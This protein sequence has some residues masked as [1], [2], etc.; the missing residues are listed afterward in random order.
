MEPF[1][2]IFQL[3][4]YD[5]LSSPMK[6]LDCI[7]EVS[8][9]ATLEKLKKLKVLAGKVRG[10]LD[11]GYTNVKGFYCEDNNEL[12]QVT[13]DTQLL[14]FVKDLVDGD[15][16]H[17]YVVHEVDE[18]KEL[19]APTGL[20]PWSDPVDESVGINTEGTVENDSDLN[21]VDTELPGGDTNQNEAE[22]DLPSS[23][24]DVDVIPDEDDSDVDEELR[25]LRAE[26]RNKRNPNLRQKR[27]REKKTITKEVPIGEAG[28]DRGFEDIGINKKDKYVGRLGGDEK[29]I[30]SS[31]CDSDDSTDMLDAEA[32][33][34]VDLPGR[35]KGKKVRYD[36]QCTVAIFELGMIFENA[37][38]FRKALAKYAVEKNYQI[39]LRPNEAHRVGVHTSQPA[40][41]S[42]QF[43]AGQS[44]QGSCHPEPTSSFQ[45]GPTRFNQ[46]ASTTSNSHASSTTVC[47][48]TSRVKRARETAK[49]SQPPLFVDTSI[50]VTR[51]ITSQ[52][53]TKTRQTAGQKRG[54]VATGEDSARGGPKR[55][56]NGGSSNVG[57]GI[58]TSDSGTQI[59]NVSLSQTVSEMNAS[60]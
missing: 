8:G 22:S 1:F 20:L 50:P 17:V 24:T 55:P 21:G 59:L 9:C 29:Y 28:V 14:E 42:S 15:E 11:L 46:P 52:L 56:T 37:K 36:D 3:P 57:F 38:E 4:S 6:T 26:R 58:Y 2:V 45:P 25:S 60:L 40:S 41:H 23:D 47:G 51:E 39:K 18:L 5:S 35:R 54:R 31:E 16:Y 13:S 33:G 32:I 48:D 44:S 43:T 34:G 30:D 27:D 49:T 10:F 19:P 53:P 12:V 7:D